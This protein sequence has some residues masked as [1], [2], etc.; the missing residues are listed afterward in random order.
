MSMNLI[1]EYHGGG[2]G[3]FPFQTPTKL[4]YRVVA[5]KTQKE[6]YAEL[7]KYMKERDFPDYIYQEVKDVVFSDNSKLNYIYKR[8]KLK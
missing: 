7:E 4:T 6:Q 8:I 3:V 5:L 2:Y 1:I